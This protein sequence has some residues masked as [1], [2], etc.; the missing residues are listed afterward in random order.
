MKD[1]RKSRKWLLGGL[2]VILLAAGLFFGVRGICF[3]RPYHPIPTRIPSSLLYAVMKAESGFREDAKS[4]AG[5]IGLMQLMP[6]TAEFVCRMNGMSFDAERL[7][8]G[9][10][11]VRLG[12][13]YLEYL[14]ARFENEVTVLA[15][16]NAGEGTVAEWLQSRT[17]S[18]DGKTLSSIPYPETERYVKKVMKFRKIYLFFYHEST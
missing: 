14:S 5:A 6:S 11:N 8:E 15:A 16:Y 4:K 7:G 13:L 2:G 9:E 12:A 3:P 17:L 1:V 18:P 10:Y